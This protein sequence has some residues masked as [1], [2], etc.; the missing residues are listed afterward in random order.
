[1]RYSRRKGE[2]PMTRSF[3]LLIAAA[4]T[5]APASA[6]T[7]QMQVCAPRDAIV[8]RLTTE[9]KET[10][11]SIGLQGSAAVFEVFASEE[12]SWTMIMTGATGVTCVLAAGD[13]WSED[14]SARLVAGDPA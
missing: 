13:T 14:V 6:E 1:M 3:I 7:P 5:L 10:R 2:I 8:D 12:G 9:F 4:A 11:R